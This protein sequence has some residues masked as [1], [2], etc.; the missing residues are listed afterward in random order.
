MGAQGMSVAGI[1]GPTG[2]SG[3]IGAQGMAGQPGGQGAT[4]VGPT[5]PTGYQ[6]AA[7]AQGSSGFTGAQGA[8]MPG[9]IGGSGSSGPPGAQ[10][11]VGPIGAQGPVGIVA[12]WSSYRVITF[13]YARSDLTPSDRSTVSDIAA[14]MTKNPSLKA[15]IDGYRDANNQNLSE[16]RVGTVRDALIAA[17]VPAYKVQVGAFGDPQLRHDR[18]VEVLLSTSSTNQSMNSQ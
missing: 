10:G 1:P 7:G 13:D 9:G 5:G 18:R 17:G 4:L 14:Y 3:P 11:P 8:T 2:P 12:A 6:G 16:R 15:G